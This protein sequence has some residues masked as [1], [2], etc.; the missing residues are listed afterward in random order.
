MRGKQWR[1]T[2]RESERFSPSIQCNITRENH[3]LQYNIV[4]YV[5]QRILFASLD[6]IVCVCVCVCRLSYLCCDL[7][8]VIVK[9]LFSSW[10]ENSEIIPIGAEALSPPALGTMISFNSFKGHFFSSFYHFYKC[11][12]KGVSAFP[13]QVSTQH[14]V[15]TTGDTVNTWRTKLNTNN[16]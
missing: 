16:I 9:G 8:K 2:Q 14:T 15:V 10:T 5:I 7:Q 4:Y 11:Q 6:H 3:A 1:N 13:H 12:E